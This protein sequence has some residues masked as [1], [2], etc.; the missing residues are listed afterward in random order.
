MTTGTR[1]PLYLSEKKDKDILDYVEPMLDQYSFSAIIRELIRDG[2]KYRE[3]SKQQSQPVAQN[4]V[5]QSNTP[6]L[7][8]IELKSKQVSKDEIENRLDSF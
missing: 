6:P 2:I 4:M 3:E 8:K 1:K 5:L 7:P